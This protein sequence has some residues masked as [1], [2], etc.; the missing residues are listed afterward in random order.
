MRVFWA[1]EP[2]DGFGRDPFSPSRCPSRLT[3]VSGRTKA[4]LREAVRGSCRKTP[5][6]YGMLDAN[7]H[8][9]YV[10][11]SKSLRTRLLSYFRAPAGREKAGAILRETSQIVWE[12]QPSEFAALLR[13]L[14]LIRSWRPRWNVKDQP[15]ARRP[16]YICL[17]RSPAKY[18]FAT[19]DPPRG[20]LAF[21]PFQG[22]GRV[23][24]AV[25][26]L[27]K[28]Y[29]LRDC[30]G[31][32][33]F[34]FSEQA[35][36]F[37]EPR[38]PGCLRYEIGTCLGPCVGGCS[39]RA[40]GK[41]VRGARAFLEGDDEAPI[42]TLQERMS[43]AAADQRF[44]TAARLRDRLGALEWL[45]VRLDYLHRAREK[46]NFVYPV[47]STSGRTIWY[48]VHRGCVA[49]ALHAPTGRRRTEAD[50][51]LLE[52]WQRLGRLEGFPIMDR[53]P[54]ITLLGHWF[55]TREGEM[56]RVLSVDEALARYRGEVACVS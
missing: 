1:A 21:G 52:K 16:V 15:K 40:Y 37:P 5:G 7:G 14:Y 22:R 42:A 9:I 24:V 39:A 10:G 30:T 47:R 27:N 2:F 19:T 55:R 4:A 43:R 12:R 54:T 35:E 23:N 20:A 45:S 34:H 11:K 36:L 44:E 46:F 49:T 17:G 26:A 48:A 56:E 6:V 32:I 31:K 13:E 18:L 53:H 33:A 3:T 51:L 25:E 41:G 28:H 29:G 8:L 50:R 38:R